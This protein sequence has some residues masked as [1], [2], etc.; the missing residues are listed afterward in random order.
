M[1]FLKGCWF[2]IVNS[3]LINVF[4]GDKEDDEKNFLQVVKLSIV[5]EKKKKENDPITM[6]DFPSVC[7][8][9]CLMANG[10]CK[11]SVASILDQGRQCIVEKSGRAFG[12]THSRSPYF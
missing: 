6:A 7:G 4:K 10:I 2:C 8:D 11:A 1:C 12:L 5:W 9:S 3:L